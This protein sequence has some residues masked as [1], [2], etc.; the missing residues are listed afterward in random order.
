MARML[1]RI[2]TGGHY[3]SGSRE[4]R[5]RVK[6]QEQREWRL[7]AERL[8]MAENPRTTVSPAVFDDLMAWIEEDD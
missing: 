2:W 5:K 4:D 7:E 6:R 3:C 8:A 1:G